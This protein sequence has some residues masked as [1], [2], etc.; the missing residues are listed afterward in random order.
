MAGLLDGGVSKV[1]EFLGP[2]VA[3]AINNAFH[4][5]HSRRAAE[6]LLARPWRL[7]HVFVTEAVSKPA[8][9]VPILRRRFIP[10]L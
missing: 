4:F 7:R 10:R 8:G 6:G 5:V 9:T 3:L 1:P 2:L